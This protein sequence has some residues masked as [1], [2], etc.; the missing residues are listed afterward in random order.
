[1]QT[2]LRSD[3]RD[4]P[5]GRAADQ[6]LRNC[7]HCGFCLATC[8]TYRLLGDE[9]D[10]PRGRIYLIKSVLEGKPAGRETQ[11]HLDRCLTCRA[12]ETTC[13]SGVEYGRLLEIGRSAVEAEIPRPWWQRLQ[14]GLLLRVLPYRRRFTPLLRLAQTLRPLLPSA[15]KQQVPQRQISNP[16]PTRPQARRII[17]F[18]G[19]VQPALAPSINA[20]AARLFDRLAIGCERI[21]GEGCCGA[22]SLHLGDERAAR[23]FARHNI[24]RW[25]PFIESGIESIIVTASGCGVMIKDYDV[26]LKDDPD[27]ADKAARVAALARDPAEY[28]NGEAQLG[29]LARCSGRI[30]FQSPCTLQHGQGLSGASER[31]LQRL[32]FELTPQSDGHQCCGSAGTYSILQPQLAKQLREKKLENLNKGDPEMI[33]TANIGCLLHL[34]QAAAVPVRHWLEVVD[35]MNSA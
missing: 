17:L 2:E 33:L 12:C 23:H 16:R 6:I 25:W 18:E 19:C 20:A 11:L 30:A 28:L 9:L 3:I 27:Y 1:M 15:L 34:Q 14:R 26:L 22:L 35:D 21:S 5:D 4:T 24:D 13:P 29:N 10:S 8:P 31:L 32:G 7:V